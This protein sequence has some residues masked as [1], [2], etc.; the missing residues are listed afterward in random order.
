MDQQTKD[1][2]KPLIECLTALSAK[3]AITLELLARHLPGLPEEEKK[4]ILA[5]AQESEKR[6]QE[7]YRSLQALK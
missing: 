5:S 7:I 3:Q 4:K 6:G 2:I 1:I